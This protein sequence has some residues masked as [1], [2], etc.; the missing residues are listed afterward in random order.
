[1]LCKVNHLEAGE[2]L[3]WRTGYYSNQIP[4]SFSYSDILTPR[5]RACRV[6]DV[7]V[8]TITDY[9]MARFVSRE[10]MIFDHFS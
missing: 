10:G 3:L 9:I 2:A 6:V 8:P 4:K 1:M 7:K 5:R